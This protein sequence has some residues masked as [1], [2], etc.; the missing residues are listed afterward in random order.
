MRTA[1]LAASFVLLPAIALAAGAPRTLS[2]LAALIVD[3]INSGTALLV[4][5]GIVVYFW[6]IT[7]NMF[8]IQKGDAG[9]A[10]QYF[11]W[12]IAIIFVM[13]SI[14]GIVRLIQETL[15][16]GGNPYGP[17]SSRVQPAFRAPQFGEFGE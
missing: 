10:K 11:L 2:A 6:G 17:S 13:V 16:G 3:I 1:M 8:K 15:F 14:W 12:G 7:T 4:L 9:V 5:A